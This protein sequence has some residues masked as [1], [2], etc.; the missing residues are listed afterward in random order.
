MKS[1]SSCPKCGRTAKNSVFSNHF[2]VNKCT[3]C[4]QLYCEKCANGNCP[5]CGATAKNTV[6]KVYA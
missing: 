1:Y 3:M 4:G 2:L 5:K 6:G